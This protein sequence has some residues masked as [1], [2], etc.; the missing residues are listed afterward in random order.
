VSVV[1]EVALGRVYVERKKTT[2]EKRERFIK[3]VKKKTRGR[4]R[5][6]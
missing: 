4:K 6:F 2:G 5:N 3:N 1:A